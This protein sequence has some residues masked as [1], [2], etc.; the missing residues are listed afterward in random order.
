MARRDGSTRL[1]IA[2][3]LSVLVHL[4]VGA[5]VARHPSTDP[6]DAVSDAPAPPVPPDDPKVGI[7]RSRH[8]TITWIG[9]ETPTEH[10][11]PEAETEQPALTRDAPS[12]P[13]QPTE[14]HIEPRPTPEQAVAAAEPARRSEADTQREP[15]TASAENG[16]GVTEPSPFS[17]TITAGPLVVLPPGEGVPIFVA[18]PVA[19]SEPREPAETKEPAETPAAAVPAAAEPVQREPAPEQSPPPPSGEPERGEV[20]SRE[21]P[22][23]S[24]NKPVVVRPG[25]P[26]AAEGLQIETRRPHLS[27][28]GQI[29]AT[30]ARLAVVATFDRRGRV[31]EVEWVKRT[32]M[33]EIDEP[34]L[35]SVYS[36]RARGKAIDDLPAGDPKAGVRVPFEIILR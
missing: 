26:A 34:V 10:E 29:R 5:A 24:L 17:Q 9:F 2:S 20:D 25:H 33:K 13:V 12:S 31:R 7:E 32:G 22:A 15:A 27:L 36:W 21:T 28:Y 18:A 14:T 4:L 23:T 3:G 16:G 6:P 35:D 19:G 30:P 1:W 11:A 8:A